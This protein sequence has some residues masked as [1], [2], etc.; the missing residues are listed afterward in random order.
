MG[1]IKRER[2]KALLNVHSYFSFGQGVSSPRSLVERAAELGYTHLGLTDNLGVFG[3]VELHS[4]AKK[5][6]V[7]AVIGSTLPLLHNGETYP[8]V[9]LAS[10]RKGY[11]TLNELTTLVKA[12]KDVLT[13]SMLEN[14]HEDLH[15]LTGGRKGFLTQLLQ[16]KKI[17]EAEKLLD[18]LK[19]TFRN[20]LWIQ[21]YFDYYPWDM[22]RIRALR[23]FAI[24]QRV[25][26][27]AAPEVRYATSDLFTLYDTLICG[28]LGI[29]LN[30][31]HP[32][33]P[34]NEYQA[35]PDAL[36]FPIPFP[37]A[38]EN[39]NNLAEELCFDLLPD[40][41]IPPPSR[42]PDG[43]TSET[44]LKSLCRESLLEKYPGHLFSEAKE[45]LE[46][47]LYTLESLGFSDFF[48]V[49]REVMQFCKSRGIV[50]SGRGSAAGSV[51][52]YLL[53]ITQADPLSNGLLFERFLHT[54]KRA[55]PDIDIDISSSRRDEVFAWVEDRFPH[56]AMVCNK[57]TYYIILSYSG[58]R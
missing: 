24:D 53:G 52:C 8:L 9:L 29:T 47:E 5:C 4:A 33:R 3:S 28:R 27:V 6:G 55:M 19:G 18:V 50:A 40:R 2:L 32:E 23:D 44:Y 35:I 11:E 25:S 10:S 17:R 39:A 36:E 26:V 49:V 54:G 16:N 45:R 46:R 22:R 43:Y 12:Q 30:T 15:V 21:L 57:V 34:I 48:L 58:C 42:L 56:S 51:I 14:Y 37:E 38:I 20:R 13:V 1:S 31:P 7:K 41:L